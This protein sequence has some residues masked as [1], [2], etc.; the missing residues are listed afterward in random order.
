[1][2]WSSI[3]GVVS[4]HEIS[5]A[6]AADEADVLVEV[7]HGADRRV[8]YDRLFAQL[9]GP[10]PDR[11]HE[12]FHVNTDVGAWA[13]AQAFA[14]HWVERRPAS[15]VLLLRCLIPRTFVDCNR[16]VD[17]DETATLAQAGLTEAIP[18]YVTG[19][20]DRQRLTELHERYVALA[21]EAYAAIC[22][23]GGL[24]LNPHTYGPRSLPIAQVD[25]TIVTELRRVHEPEV[26]AKSR[27][28][29]HV[30]VISIDDEGRDYAP[31]RMGLAVAEA[32]RPLGLVTEFAKT[33]RLHPVTQGWRYAT[34]HPGQ[35]FGF[36]VRRDLL[37]A[38]SPFAEQ[39]IDEARVEAIGRA[40]A[41]GVD[42]SWTGT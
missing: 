41:Q 29:P 27:L 42:A 28:R 5:G 32:L 22:G 15:R 17:F 34:R 7:P 25:G 3:E 23:Q 19:I 9:E 18:P 24:A 20:A 6:E 14:R 10:F 8:H 38:W 36:E 39:E 30:D 33:Y 12:F 11:L 21:D 40:L 37:C 1:M 16:R 13:I 2:A 35:V 4:V 26:Y 31:A